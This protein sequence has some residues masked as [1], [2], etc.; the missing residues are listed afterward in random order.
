VEL[1]E[2]LL[3]HDPKWNRQTIKAASVSG[4]QRVVNL[5]QQVPVYLLYW[6]AWIDE[7]GLL[8]F[9]DDIY[10]RDKPMVRALFQDGAKPASKGA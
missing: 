8:N 5:P 1:A 9:R 3:K 10:N 6:T 4:K 7:N 2:Y